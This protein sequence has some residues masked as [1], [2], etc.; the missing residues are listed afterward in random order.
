MRLDEICADSNLLL[1]DYLTQ[2]YELL[3]KKSQL[4]NK[5]KKLQLNKL[6]VWLCGYTTSLNL[7]K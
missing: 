5:F 3:L 2:N 7:S 1:N 6:Q 4:K